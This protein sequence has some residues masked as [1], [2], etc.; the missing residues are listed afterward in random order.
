MATYETRITIHDPGRLEL[1]NLPFRAGQQ[2]K[3]IVMTE[4]DDRDDRV[5]RWRELFK[6]T[7]SLPQAQTLT[8]NEIAAEIHA[9]REGR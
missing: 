2:V 7:Q 8:E 3:V 1:Q 5:R 9:Y 4:E 6:Q